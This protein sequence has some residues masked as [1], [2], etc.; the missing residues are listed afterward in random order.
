MQDLRPAELNA[1]FDEQPAT[2]LN[3]NLLKALKKGYPA[4]TERLR[5]AGGEPVILI[6]L[7]KITKK[8]TCTSIK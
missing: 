2:M 6:V 8:L 7:D 3:A 1:N 4:I 5:T